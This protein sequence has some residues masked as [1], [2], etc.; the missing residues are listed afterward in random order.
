MEIKPLTISGSFEISTLLFPDD[1]G[2]F[3]E[4]FKLN[5][6][7]EALGHDFVLRQA[8][9]SVSHRGVL[10]GIHFADVPPG[11]A[12]YVMVPHGA[13]IDFIVDIRAGSPTF[14]KWQSVE[15]NDQLRNAVYLAEGI[16]HAFLS[17]TDNTVVNYL[18]SDFYNPEH[19]HG[20][21]PLDEDI[22]LEFP[23]DSSELIIS[24][25]DLA[26]PT[27]GELLLK[28]QLPD[29]EKCNDYYASLALESL[30]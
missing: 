19:E 15:I 20:I 9:L 18:V 10:R 4:S 13:I 29:F 21:H 7:S 17:L 6:L 5:S 14:G 12:K 25:K 30:E 27:L 16:G 11:Q 26:A 23:I 1:R 2:V 24:S 8:N 22:N 28:N 3:L